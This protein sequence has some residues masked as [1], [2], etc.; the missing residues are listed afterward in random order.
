MN[1]F[2][3]VLNALAGTGTSY[4]IAVEAKHLPILIHRAVRLT[5]HDTADRHPLVEELARLQLALP[6]LDHLVRY[7]STT[8]SYP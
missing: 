2:L 6:A 4:I 3:E 7:C 1:T 5:V 8:S